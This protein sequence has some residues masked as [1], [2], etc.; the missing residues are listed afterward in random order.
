LIWLFCC[1]LIFKCRKLEEDATIVNAR[2]MEIDAPGPFSDIHT[3]TERLRSET[4]PE[5]ISIAQP[6]LLGNART[7]K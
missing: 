1:L 7:H 5:W 4:C 6:L 2:W 3:H